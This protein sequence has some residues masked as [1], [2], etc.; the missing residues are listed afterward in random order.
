MSIPNEEANT[1]TEKVWIAVRNK[2]AALPSENA[3]KESDS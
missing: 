1:S 3:D 2:R